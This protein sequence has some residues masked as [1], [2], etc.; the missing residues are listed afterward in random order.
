[1]GGVYVRAFAGF[2]PN[3]VVGVIMVDPADFTESK[4]DWNSIFRTIGVPE[5]KIDEM[6][7]E[8]LYKPSAIDSAYYG[9]W[10]E[11][12]VLSELRRTDFAEIQRLPM[13]NVPVYFL[14]GGRFEVPA[15][16]QSKD[17]DHPRFF[18][19]KSNRNMERWRAFLDSSSKGGQLIY[20]PNCGHYI[21]R[22]DP[23]AVINSIKY[24]LNS[25]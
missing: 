2:Y 25:L 15:D 24:M 13:P 7:Y 16:Y 3:D 8:R 19:V 20:L 6:M 18:I 11:G 12:Q 5:K 10:S 21:H 14:V 23:K 1:M 17:F 9:P 22:D 4:D